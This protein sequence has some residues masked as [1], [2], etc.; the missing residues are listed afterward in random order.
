MCP[1][2]TISGG[3]SRNRTFW[4]NQFWSFLLLAQLVELLFVNLELP[5]PWPWPTGAKM[6]VLSEAC[7]AGIA[8]EFA[9]V[10]AAGMDAV[11]ATV[12]G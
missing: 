8:M 4:N 3:S 9:C 11:L 7:T 2:R 6:D 12:D 5:R 10:V 1:I